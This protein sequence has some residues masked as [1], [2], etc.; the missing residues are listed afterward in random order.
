[1]GFYELSV[2]TVVCE[3]IGVAYQIEV[4]HGAGHGDI[5]LTVDLLTVGIGEVGAGEEV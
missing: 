2:Y 1:M 3:H 4:F 5:E